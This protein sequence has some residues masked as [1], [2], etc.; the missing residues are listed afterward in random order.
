MSQNSSDDFM[1]RYRLEL[2]SNAQITTQFGPGNA[3]T[4]FAFGVE[5]VKKSWWLDRRAEK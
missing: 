1:D 2:P 3:C 4:E 5:A